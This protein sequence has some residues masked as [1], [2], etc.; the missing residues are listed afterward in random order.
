MRGKSRGRK[1]LKGYCED[2]GVWDDELKETEG[3]LLC[4]ECRR[5]RSKEGN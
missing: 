1:A 3:L 4:N 5:F 2:C